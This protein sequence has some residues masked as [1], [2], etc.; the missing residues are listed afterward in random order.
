METLETHNATWGSAST[1]HHPQTSSST[2]SQ[3]HTDG[4]NVT[5]LE[6]TGSGFWSFFND[7]TDGSYSNAGCPN[8]NNICQENMVIMTSTTSL[9]WYNLLSKATTNIIRDNGNV[10]TQNNNPGGWGPEGGIIAAYLKDSG[11]SNEQ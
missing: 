2:V 9:F 11:I 8:H 4:Y 1:S 6:C 3:F 7:M 5:N 10:V